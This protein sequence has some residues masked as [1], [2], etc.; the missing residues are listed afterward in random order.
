MNDG[1]LLVAFIL[2]YVWLLKDR[3]KRMHTCKDPDHLAAVARLD[4]FALRVDQLI[5]AGYL[6]KEAERIAASHSLFA[7]KD[8][9]PNDNPHD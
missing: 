8:T 7:K 1:M 4:P 5:G 3:P 9:K 2:A 6:R